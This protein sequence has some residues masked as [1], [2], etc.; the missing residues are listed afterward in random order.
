VKD[1][2]VTAELTV[3]EESARTPE[4]AAMIE[5]L[6]AELG[7]LYGDDGTAYFTPADV[8]QPGGLFVVARLGG[9]AVGCG[10]LRPWEHSTEGEWV[11]EVKR[12]YV[13]PG[14]RGR[15]IGRRVLAVIEARAAALGYTRLSLETGWRQPDAMALYE[16]AGWRM[17]P[18]VGRY[19]GDP[20]SVC[21][22]KGL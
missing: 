6:S 9:E 19:A 5:A 2:E 21:Y 4:A 14:L 7:A 16:R 12:M 10:A 20:E 22:E 18:C 1:A 8:E 13:A 15:G 17:C 11:G 3:A